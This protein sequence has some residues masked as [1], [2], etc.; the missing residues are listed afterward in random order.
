MVMV[1]PEFS[2]IEP[3]VRQSSHPM[4]SQENDGRLS[5]SLCMDFVMTSY[6]HSEES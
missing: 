3:L 6:K 4:S 1:I 2:F 5:V